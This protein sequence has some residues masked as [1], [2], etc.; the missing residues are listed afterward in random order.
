MKYGFLVRQKELIEFDGAKQLHWVKQAIELYK[1]DKGLL[2]FRT[3]T[4]SLRGSVTRFDRYFNHFKKEIETCHINECKFFE[5]DWNVRN[6][7][8][9]LSEEA[10]KYLY[11]MREEC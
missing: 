10:W 6:E 4:I 8:K 7:W 9:K 11:K 2:H 3:G 1:I 5:G